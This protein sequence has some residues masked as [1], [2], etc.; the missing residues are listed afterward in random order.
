[1]P[2]HLTAGVFTLDEKAPPELHTL[3]P[4]AGCIFIKAGHLHTGF[5]TAVDD[6]GT[7]HTC[8]GNTNP[9]GSSDG[10][11][12]YVRTRRR[13]ELMSFLDLNAV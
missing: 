4:A 13:A 2:I 7:I 1:V 6:D 11:G 8:E 3:N 9:G 5:V 10:D 12:V